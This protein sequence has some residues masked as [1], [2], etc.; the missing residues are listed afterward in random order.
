[1]IFIPVLQ[2]I[3]PLS[4]LSGSFCRVEFHSPAVLDSGPDI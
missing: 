3:S 4:C 2:I 1:M